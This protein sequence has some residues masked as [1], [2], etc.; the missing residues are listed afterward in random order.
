M[1]K[2][3]ASAAN[4]TNAQSN[5]PMAASAITTVF[6]SHQPNHLSLMYAAKTISKICDI[7]MRLSDYW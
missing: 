1:F 2:E 4:I 7:C 5:I 3:V 6:L